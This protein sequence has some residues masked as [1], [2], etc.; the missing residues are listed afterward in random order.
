[1]SESLSNNRSWSLTRRQA[2][3]VLWDVRECSYCGETGTSEHGPDGHAWHFDHVIPRA[4]GGTHDPKNIVKACRSCNIR[5]GASLEPIW[6]PTADVMTA[7]GTRYGD[8]DALLR[9]F[10]DYKSKYDWVEK[11]LVQATN[12]LDDAIEEIRDLETKLARAEGLRQV[13]VKIFGSSEAITDVLQGLDN[14]Q[15]LP[16]AKCIRKRRFKK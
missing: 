13:L 5:K 4:H 2:Y 15:Y 9:M 12:D 16:T 7:A 1:M 3:L 14:E 11:R 8:D 10:Q 6:S